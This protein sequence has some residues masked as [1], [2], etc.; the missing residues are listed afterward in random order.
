MVLYRN[1]YLPI[2]YN[3]WTTTT[4]VNEIRATLNK[5]YLVLQAMGQDRAKDPLSLCKI[6]HSP[7]NVTFNR[8]PDVY[9]FDLTRVILSSISNDYINASHI[10]SIDAKKKYIATQ[11]PLPT[12]FV[13]FWEMVWEQHTAVIVMLTKEEESGRV[14]CHRYW[15]ENVG[16]T[17][18]YHK[19][20]GDNTVC[21]KIFFAEQIIMPDGHTVI[22]ELAVKREMLL[23]NHGDRAIPEIRLIRIINFLAWDDHDSCDPRALL[24]LVDMSNEINKLAQSDVLILGTQSSEFVIGPMV[25]LCSAGIGRTGTFCAVDAVIH[26]MT[27]SIP[28]GATFEIN[29]NRLPPFDLIAQTV[30]HFRQQRPGFVQTSAQFYL[31]YEAI[32]LRIVDLFHLREPASWPCLNVRDKDEE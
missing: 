24:S 22:R 16:E 25:I 15:P 29:G 20:E 9:P 21:F 4:N 27:H 14:K 11:G 1:K 18:R 28:K 10:I 13:D 12:T 5:L 17:K 2:W 3:F 30:N 32:L 7:N 8:Y 31:I 19:I 6:A 26:H 23:R